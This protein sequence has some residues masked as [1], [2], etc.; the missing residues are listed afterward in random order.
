MAKITTGPQV[1]TKMRARRLK[2][3]WT[4]RR[5]AEECALRGVPVDHSNLA[6]IERG[7]IKTPLPELWGVLVRTLN[8]PENY[9]HEE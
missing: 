8:L 1:R 5:L 9:F 4:L 7:E 2:K 3:G 6:R